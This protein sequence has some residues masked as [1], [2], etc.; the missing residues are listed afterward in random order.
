MIGT[1]YFHS[2]PVHA[3]ID[4]LYWLHF[5]L[6]VNIYLRT[7]H[8]MKLWSCIRFQWINYCSWI[9]SPV[10]GVQWVGLAPLNLYPTIIQ[11]SVSMQIGGQLNET[12]RRSWPKH[13]KLGTVC[14]FLRVLFPEFHASISNWN[15]AE[16]DS[17][18]E[19]CSPSSVILAK[20]VNIRS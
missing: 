9:R 20:I 13:W 8:A 2:H 7:L 4:F 19:N 18:K 14:Y 16:L 17:L 11:M 5:K 15:L 12:M 6:A 1:S 3:V 10:P